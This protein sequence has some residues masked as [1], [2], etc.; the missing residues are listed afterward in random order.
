[1]ACLMVPHYHSSLGI[2]LCYIF[3]DFGSTQATPRR[4]YSLGKSETRHFDS[5][6]QRRHCSDFTQTSTSTLQ[7]LILVG[8]ALGVSGLRVVGNEGLAKKM[9][10]TS[11][12]QVPL[13]GLWGGLGIFK[14]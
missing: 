3:M 5:K 13:K 1:M 10:T 9:D 14:M 12:P 4:D 11:G 7:D 6:T 2:Q 8:K